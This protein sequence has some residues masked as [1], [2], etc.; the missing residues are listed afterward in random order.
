[1]ENNDTPMD[2][3]PVEVKQEPKKRGRK[4]KAKT[5]IE[6]IDVEPEMEVSQEADPSP[7][8]TPGP[9]SSEPEAMQ[10]EA[11]P[12]AEVK[13]KT[14]RTTKPRVKKEIVKVE[15]EA[16]ETTEMPVPR[17]LTPE[18][19]RVLMHELMRKQTFDKKT[20]KQEKYKRLMS[21]AF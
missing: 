15:A 1:M 10:V 18:E 14:K 5:V 11:D 4:A 9:I 3:Q 6:K 19:Q 8:A 13:V 2:T 21:S 16:E 12:V 20:A 7:V 17:E